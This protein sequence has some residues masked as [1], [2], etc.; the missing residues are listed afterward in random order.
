MRGPH[1]HLIIGDGASSA[2]LADTLALKS[3]DRLTILGANAGQFGRGLAYA[4]YPSDVPWRYAHLMNSP[5]GAFGE[6]FVKWFEANW[7]DIRPR[8]AA[9]QPRWLDFAADHMAAGDFGAVFAPRAVFGDY[10]AEI[11]RGTLAAHA[12]M[13]VTV[14]QRTALATDLAKDEHGFRITLATGEVIRADRVDVATGGPSP[15]RFG[16]DSG[17]TAFTTLYGNEQAI[18]EVLRPKQEMTCLGG[19]AAMLDVLRLMQSI[20]DE[21]D[22][23]LR[24]ITRG[25]KPEPLIWTRPRK[26]PV[27]PK[28]TGPYRD[29]ETLLAAVD[30]EIAAFRAKGASMAE[31]RPGYLDW[32]AKTGLERLLPS[33]SERRKVIPQLERRFRRATHD[34][35]A[36]YARLRAAGQIVEEHGEITWVFAETEGKTRIR[37]K[38]AGMGT[39]EEIATSVVINTSGPGDQLAVDLLTSGLIRNGWLRMNETKTGLIVGPGLETEVEGLRYLSPAVTEIGAEVLA[40]PLEDVSALAARAKVANQ[41]AI[42]ERLQS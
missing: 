34:S 31:L 6:G 9:H 38:R 32:A 27:T 36:D 21:Q 17:P 11:G 12:A 20:M 18:A 14:Q 40:F 41:I 13:G 26:E 10:L 2:A 29:A 33:L 24:V 25:F 28:L 39:N 19:N 7:G 37:L 3:G 23:R 15:Q 42:H 5:S 8:I 35:L 22:I 30:A 16:A 1:H 4:D